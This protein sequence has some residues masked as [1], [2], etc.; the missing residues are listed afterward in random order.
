V[1]E[2]R[3][4]TTCTEKD[5]CEC[6][7]D[8]CHRAPPVMEP[9]AILTLSWV[10]LELGLYLGLL[11]SVTLSSTP[12]K[13]C[14]KDKKV[15]RLG[16]GAWGGVGWGRGFHQT[17]TYLWAQTWLSSRDGCS[18]ASLHAAEKR[19]VWERLRHSPYLSPA[20]QSHLPLHG[21]QRSASF[22]IS[23]TS[24]RA[25]ASPYPARS[26]VQLQRHRP[27]PP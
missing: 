14:S 16:K 13:A 11:E 26:P 6:I 22:H 25:D 9:G 18:R 2:D 5:R 20:P 3:V 4:S 7:S 17:K 8:P 19:A 1:A 27:Y 23:H 10:G 21:S 15:V 12:S 24:D